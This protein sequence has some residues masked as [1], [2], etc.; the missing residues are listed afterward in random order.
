VREE[1]TVFAGM[2]VCQ[3]DG[4]LLPEKRNIPNIL[5]SVQN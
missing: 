1:L 5:D 4:G 2:G 3:F